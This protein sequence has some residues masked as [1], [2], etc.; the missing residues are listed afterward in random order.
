MNTP[1]NQLH[2][3]M[4]AVAIACQI[5]RAVQERLQEVTALT[6]DDR[7]PVTVADYA[8]QAI[9]ALTLQDMLED[10]ADHRIV[11]EEDAL[12]LADEESAIVR[13]AIVEV[14]QHWR[15]GIEE[16]E[17]LAAIDSCDHDGTAD[18]Y[19]TL[20]PVDGTK[21]FLRGQQYA[22]ALG[23]IEHGRV[24]AGVMGCPALPVSQDAPLDT[25]DSHGVLYAAAEGQG[26]WEFAGCDPEAQ[27]LRILTRPGQDG[28][29]WRFCGS[30]EKAHSNRSDSDRVA[31]IVGNVGE[32]VR[33]DSQCKYAMVARG[34]ADAYLRLPT[35]AGYV[36][37][38]WDHAA[39]SVIAREAGAIVTDIHG[40]PLDFGQGARLERNRG[41]ICAS[42]DVHGCIIGAI[43][44]L[45]IDAESKD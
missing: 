25:P 45:G 33:L 20:D 29:P 3:A 14:V 28:R 40:R 16:Q 21:G 6:K 44:Q 12:G 34:Q 10:P 24:V 19:W 18:T 13:R 7:S 35:R 8:A 9:V 26:A 4:Q 15:N 38:I 42:P 2:A 32:P 27:R 30:V 41:V 43:D 23:R 39:G 11:G 17:V 31:E 36:E 22:I 5:T 1:S 37:K